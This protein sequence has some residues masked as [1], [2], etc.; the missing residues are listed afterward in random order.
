MVTW[1]LRFDDADLGS[2]LPRAACF[3]RRFQSILVIF[4]SVPSG[5]LD[6]LVKTV[7][8]LT[9]PMNEIVESR[10][11]G[12]LDKRLIISTPANE[13]SFSVGDLEQKCA[14][15]SIQLVNTEATNEP[16]AGLDGV[17]ADV[18]WANQLLSLW[19]LNKENEEV[20]LLGAVVYVSKNYVI[21][22]GWMALTDSAAFFIPSHQIEA[23]PQP[24]VMPALRISR[25]RSQS[26]EPG[27]LLLNMAGSEM[28]FLCRAT[29]GEFGGNGVTY[30]RKQSRCRQ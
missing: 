28:K 10:V 30:Q 23:G 24:L 5:A 6:A 8:V 25:T 15:L 27:E 11:K 29:L 9:I 22:R 12:R 2:P 7:D 3:A 18:D 17:V 14:E 21:R 1:I 4:D 19:E 16:S 26:T 13:F 20:L